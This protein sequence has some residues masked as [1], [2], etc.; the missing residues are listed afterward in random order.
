MMVQITKEEVRKI[1][2]ALSKTK[3]KIF[4]R[5]VNCE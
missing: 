3:F 1:S 5:D 4:L 2:K